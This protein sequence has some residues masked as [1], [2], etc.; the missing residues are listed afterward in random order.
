M[1]PPEIYQTAMTG[2]KMQRYLS[3]TK[4]K[5][6]KKRQKVA[7]GSNGRGGVVGFVLHRG[8]LLLQHTG[9]KTKG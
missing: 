8:V 6:N 7:Y 9:D 3:D 2:H 5:W 1:L 4:R